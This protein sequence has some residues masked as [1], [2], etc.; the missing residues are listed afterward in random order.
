VDIVIDTMTGKEFA[1]LINA[2]EA[3]HGHKKHPV[4]IIKA[5]PDQSKHLETATMNLGDIG[6][7]DF[8]NLRAETYSE[9][10]RIPEVVTIVDFLYYWLL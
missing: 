1:D 10:H 4:G 9:E 8:V 7:V 5:N 2:Y 6:W 3:D